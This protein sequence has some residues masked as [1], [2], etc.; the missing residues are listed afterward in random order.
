MDEVALA[1]RAA[2][3]GKLAATTTWCPRR[4]FEKDAV[5]S[6]DLGRA[7]EMVDHSL[8]AFRVHE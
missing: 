7:M 1:Q 3:V 5:L 2:E 4:E 6:Q 8:E